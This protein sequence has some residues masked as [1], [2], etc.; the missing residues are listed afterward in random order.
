MKC[1]I[2]QH[3]DTSQTETVRQ[4]SSP[5]SR[6]RSEDVTLRDRLELE[7]QTSSSDYEYQQV[8]VTNLQLA[9][10]MALLFPQLD[11]ISLTLF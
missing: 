6:T 5:L 3:K 9:V 8:Q 11:N 2:I 7:F 1:Q 4:T 10:A